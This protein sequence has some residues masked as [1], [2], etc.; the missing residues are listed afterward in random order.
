MA[1]MLQLLFILMACG[2]GLVTL[3]TVEQRV[4]FN[5]H[6]GAAVAHAADAAVER[7]LVDLWPLADFSPVLAGSAVSSF[8]SGGP[9]PVLPDG[10]QGSLAAMTN[11][12]QA[13][14]DADATW[15][16]D[17][18]RWTLYAFGPINDLAGAAG[19]ASQE[20]LVAWVADDRADGDNDPAAD[21]N[22]LV[23]VLG[24]AYGATGSRTMEVVIRERTVVSWRE[25]Q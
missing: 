4:A 23:V 10:T 17:R 1:I 12:V 9:M 5:Q 18:P 20:Y 16:G 21:A 15:G 7:A 2:Y 19:P 14:T 22:G 13:I 3:V 11:D 24:R 8:R 25:W 6:A